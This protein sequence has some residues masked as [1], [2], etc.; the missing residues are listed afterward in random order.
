MVH[1][2]DLL[3]FFQSSR[4]CGVPLPLPRLSHID[5]PND[6]RYFETWGELHQITIADDH[7]LLWGEL[8]GFPRPLPEMF[9]STL[10]VKIWCV[11]QKTK[12]YFE[13][14]EILW[15]MTIASICLP[16]SLTGRTSSSSAVLCQKPNFLITMRFWEQKRFLH[17]SITEGIIVFKGRR[18]DFSD[19]IVYDIVCTLF[20]CGANLLNKRC[21]SFRVVHLPVLLTDWIKT[22]ADTICI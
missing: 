18:F 2:W 8:A 11:F 5:E 1:K 17:V 3:L 14:T 6:I 13:T 22:S 7:A 21:Y 12:D 15:S 9:P 10:S 20:N 4:L 16:F 19:V